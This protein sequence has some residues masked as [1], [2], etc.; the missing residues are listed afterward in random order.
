MGR[1]ES[2]ADEQVVADQLAALDDGD[3]AH[4]VGEDVHVVVRRYG[5]ARL[6]LPGQVGLAVQRVHRGAAVIEVGGRRQVGV[7]LVDGGTSLGDLVAQPEVHLHAVHPDGVVGRRAGKQRLGEREGVVL[8]RLRDGVHGGVRRGGYVAIHVAAGRQGGGEGVVDRLDERTDSL[9]HHAVELKGLSGR[10]AERAVGEAPGK[11]V[12][13][14]VLGRGDDAARLPRAHH[15]REDL[16]R[17]ALVAVIL[18]VDAVELDELLVVAAETVGGRVGQGLPD[19]AGKVRFFRLE[20]FVLGQGLLSG[21][22]HGD[23]ILD[24]LTNDYKIRSSL[25]KW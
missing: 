25:K 8:D 1:A 2:A 10:D 21:F 17:L 19:R 16:A 9:L 11:V 6:E 23:L 4:V 14:Q 15:D 20:E 24:N 22:I 13:H 18:L 12:I 7:G 3:E 5:E